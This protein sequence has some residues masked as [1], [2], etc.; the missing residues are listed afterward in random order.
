[1]WYRNGRTMMGDENYPIT[2]AKKLHNLSVFCKMYRD[3]RK[4][5]PAG[6]MFVKNP[7][8]QDTGNEYNK[9]IVRRAVNAVP[10]HLLMRTGT[11][12]PH[13]SA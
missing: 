11:L 7:I 9:E 6:E 12:G 2:I 4:T 3:G 8:L 10:A 13:A 5:A 1:M